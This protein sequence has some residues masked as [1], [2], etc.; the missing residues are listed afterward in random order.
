MMWRDL[1][2]F[3]QFHLDGK[4]HRKGWYRGNPVLPDPPRA[5]DYA[6]APILPVRSYRR[7]KFSSSPFTVIFFNPGTIRPGF[8]IID[9]GAMAEVPLN[10]FENTCLE[11]FSRLPAQFVFNLA[12]IDRVA[13]VM[14]RAIRNKRYKTA[15][16]CAKLGSKRI[17]Q[18]ADRLYNLDVGFLF[19]P[20]VVRLAGNAGTSTRQIALQ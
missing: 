11:G 14:A 20:Y 18:D 12:C 1:Q 5:K 17:K 19:N 2:Q 13:A 7:A 8:Y 10:R 9:P 6:G 4:S 15:I 16:R 3:P